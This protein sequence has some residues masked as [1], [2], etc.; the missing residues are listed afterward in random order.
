MVSIEELE[1]RVGKRVTL[2]RDITGHCWV[3]RTK[4]KLYSVPDSYIQK[5][6]II[7]TLDLVVE[8]LK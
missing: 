6:G 3:F 8:N 7:K 5:H 1:K 4:G 2:D